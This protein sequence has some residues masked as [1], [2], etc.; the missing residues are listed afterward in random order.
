M[1]EANARVMDMVRRELEKDRGVATDTLFEKAVAI[2]ADVGKLTSRQ[3]HAKYPLQVKRAMKGGSRKRAAKKRA[4]KKRTAKKAT[5][6]RATR[7]RATKKRAAKKT[8]AKKATTKRTA[9][10]AS[11]RAARKTAKQAART[12]TKRR[13]R[14]AAAAGGSDRDRVRGLLLQFAKEVAG[15]D[16]KEDMVDV[17]TGLEGWVDRVLAA[18]A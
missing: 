18:S 7:K 9:R 12:T 3:F 2:D 17:M 16:G 8:G 15:A 1:A 10:K 11:R 13:A 5:A 6:K 4:T 14:R